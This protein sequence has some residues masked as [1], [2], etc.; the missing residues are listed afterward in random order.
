DAGRVKLHR[1]RTDREYVRMVRGDSEIYGPLREI[2]RAV[3][4]VRWGGARRPSTD[5][6]RA[7][8]EAASRI[9]KVAGVVV[10]V[11]VLTAANG[12]DRY[13]PHGDAALHDLFSD[14]GYDAHWRLR[15]IAKL[16]E[17]TDVLVLDLTQV[18]LLD[19]DDAVLRSWVGDGGILVV[20]G[21]ASEAF[22]ELGDL[23]RLAPVDDGVAPGVDAWVDAV[24][25]PG[26][27]MAWKGGSGRAW[28]WIS[29]PTGGTLFVPVGDRPATVQAMPWGAGGI[30][31]LGDGRLLSNVA[32]LHPANER[33]VGLAPMLGQF[34]SMWYLDRV[35]RLEIA[36][37]NA[38][39]AG[40]PMESIANAALLPAVLQLLLLAL[41]AAAWKG[42]P[43]RPLRDPPEEGRLSFAEHVRALGTHYSRRGGSRRAASAYAN[44][45]LTVSGKRALEEA[46]R[47]AGLTDE[48]AR[49]L[50]TRAEA[51]AH[52]PDDAASPHL[53][54][55]LME[56]LW[57]I[58]PTR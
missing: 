31:A 5:K 51:A 40:S 26:N 58:D 21:D 50:V 1:S 42:I 12:D 2:F 43:F 25:L 20:A 30:V 44:L 28:S 14:Y 47:R 33:M 29:E 36:T 37:L 38:A 49:D 8:F 39:S 15:P 54:L 41:V 18:D 55:K 27:V 11:A 10:L 17:S 13:A 35:P 56:E 53:D 34:T 24:R 46:A 48:A 32:L 23:E 7:V 9:L 45:L 57:K 52:N 19:G 16:D 4:R 22:S 3:E 6:V